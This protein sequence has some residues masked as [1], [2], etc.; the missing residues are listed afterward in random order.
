MTLR[1]WNTETK[2]Y[3]EIELPTAASLITELEVL[4]YCINGNLTEAQTGIK[5][6]FKRID[7]LTEDLKKWN[8][9]EG[10]KRFPIN[11]YFQHYRLQIALY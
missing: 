3:D 1:V 8:K 5:Y 6:N 7:G 10:V 2:A 4:G 11:K 9:E